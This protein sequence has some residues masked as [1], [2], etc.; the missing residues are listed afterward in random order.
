MKQ[1]NM[2]NYQKNRS[3]ILETET[4]T[5]IRKMAKRGEKISFYAVAKATKRS[6]R[7]LYN[8]EKIRAE[9]DSLRKSP[10]PKTETTAKAETT[11]IRL[12]CKRLHNKLN[13]L[14]AENSETWKQKYLAEHKKFI[15]A[16]K[17]IQELKK[18][19]KSLYSEPTEKA[20]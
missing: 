5:T 13:K 3:E 1:D 17:E 12:E 15:S 4:L 6:V 16:F 9:I 20:K 19:L 10:A 7:Y 8:N 18:Q 2:I 14:Q 11:I